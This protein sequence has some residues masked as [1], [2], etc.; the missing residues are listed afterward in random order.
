VPPRRTPRSRALVL[1]SLKA[2]LKS[3]PLLNPHVLDP[4]ATTRLTVSCCWRLDAPVFKH[5]ENP[6]KLFD[7][8]C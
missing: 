6:F 3:H 5:A 2:G 1:F 7:L 4:A 8:I